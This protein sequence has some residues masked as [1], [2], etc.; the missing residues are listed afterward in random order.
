SSRARRAGGPVIRVKGRRSTRLSMS[1]T[2]IWVAAP[3]ITTTACAST[4][5]PDGNSYISDAYCGP[6]PKYQRPGHTL[7]RHFRKSTYRETETTSDRINPAVAA[8]RASEPTEWL[9]NSGD[10]VPLAGGRIVS[11]Y[12]VMSDAIT[13][14]YEDIGNV[15]IERGELTTALEEYLRSE[16]TFDTLAPNAPA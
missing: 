3:S 10:G 6:A 1:A 16:E 8:S 9:G 2:R 14:L 15:L 12:S 5:Q 4:S 11:F 13:V 7:R